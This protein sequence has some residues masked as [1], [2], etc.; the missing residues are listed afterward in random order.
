GSGVTALVTRPPSATRSMTPTS[1]RPNPAVPAASN[2]GFWNVV[3]R[4]V[5]ELTAARPAVYRVASPDARRGGP[6]GLHGRGGV[7]RSLPAAHPRPPGRAR[8]RAA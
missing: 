3:P 4:T 6:G 5:T 2:T 8:V 1:S 7:R